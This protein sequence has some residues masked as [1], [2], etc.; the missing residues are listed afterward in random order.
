VTEAGGRVT[1]ISGRDL[2]FC[3]GYKLEKNRGVVATNTPVHEDVLE[4][5]RDLGVGE[6]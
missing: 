5:I 6:S 2:D 4:A 3:L 1:D